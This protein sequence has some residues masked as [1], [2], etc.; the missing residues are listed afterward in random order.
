M[1]KEAA[2]REDPKAKPDPRS[3]PDPKAKPDVRAM[4]DA[5]AGTGAKTQEAHP[6][7][8]RRRALLFALLGMLVLAAAGA[9]QLAQDEPEPKAA[10]ADSPDAA[11]AEKPEKPE[12]VEPA[13]PPQFVAL[14]ALTVNLREDGSAEH[15]LQVGLTYQVSGSQVAD[16][17][18]LHMPV[19]RSNILLLL[20]SK[21]PKEI[22]T[23]QGKARLSEELLVAARQ[24]LPGDEDTP[25]GISAVHYSSFIIQ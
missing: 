19:I 18:K 14:E 11:K 9:W 17:M 23:L 4:P 21:A 15:Y 5:K 1:T 12:K 6:P 16:A 7:R 22:A 2:L 10:A 3:K 25:K 24:P 20:S 8:K 13:K